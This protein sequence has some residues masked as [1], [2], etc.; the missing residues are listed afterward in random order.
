M[1]IEHITSWIRI[2]SHG[3]S[4]DGYKDVEVKTLLGTWILSKRFEQSDD[5]MAT[6]LA[7]HIDHLRSNNGKQ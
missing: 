1:T 2:V 3:N 5:Y 6:N 4:L 7:A